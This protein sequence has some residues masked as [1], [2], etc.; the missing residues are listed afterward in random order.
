MGLL[1]KLFGTAE[2]RPAKPYVDAG[3]RLTQKLITSLRLAGW[4][5][6]LPVYSPEEIEVIERQLQNSNAKPTR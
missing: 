2:K 4:E 6:L 1:S 3:M 5:N